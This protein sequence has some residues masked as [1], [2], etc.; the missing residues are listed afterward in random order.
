MHVAHTIQQCTQNSNQLKPNSKFKNHP[1]SSVVE[2]Y[3]GKK[4]EP[5]RDLPEWRFE[6]YLGWHE[7]VG[8]WVFICIYNIYLYIYI[9]GVHIWVGLV[10]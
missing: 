4:F 3:M 9:G 1:N 10:E 6:D 8:R 7:Q 5:F 2:Q